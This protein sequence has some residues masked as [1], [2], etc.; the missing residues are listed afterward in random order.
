MMIIII[1]HFGHIYWESIK[2]SGLLYGVFPQNWTLV[3]DKIVK[4]VAIPE[5]P[6]AVE[7]PFSLPRPFVDG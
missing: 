3:R 7:K 5:R 4:F 1:L 2:S 6:P